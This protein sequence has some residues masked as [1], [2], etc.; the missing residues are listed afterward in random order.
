M[1][2]RLLN[3]SMPDRPNWTFSANDL[4]DNSP[5]AVIEW[6]AELRSSLWSKRAEEIFGWSAEEVRGRRLQDLAFIH[7]D[8]QARVAGVLEPFL[9]G[10][11]PWVVFQCRSHRKDGS[12]AYCVWYCTS[13]HDASG[14]L[15]RILTQVLDVTERELALTRLEESERRF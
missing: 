10:Q 5:L 11:L 15:L 4:V 14:K 1:S 6:D 13:V 8:D 2:A 3:V 12:V 7:E 9:A